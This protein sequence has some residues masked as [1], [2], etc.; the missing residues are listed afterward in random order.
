[1]D[2][3]KSSSPSLFQD[4]SQGGLYQLAT[5]WSFTLRGANQPGWKAAAARRL[6]ARELLAGRATGRVEM[7]KQRWVELLKG[8]ELQG[9][10]PIVWDRISFALFKD[11][12]Y[13]WHWLSHCSG[14]TSLPEETHKHGNPLTQL[15]LN[16]S[17]Q[18]S[19]LFLKKP[20]TNGDSQLHLTIL[21]L[22][23]RWQSF[24]IFHLNFPCSLSSL[25][26]VLY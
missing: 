9:T 4:L 16:H 17:W 13:C 5:G 26:L 2:F 19:N 21:Q 3:E 14:S 22:S 1:M 11:P 18:L 6:V 10:S 8:Q 23:W 12:L 24:L 15:H 25:L 7:W 20:F